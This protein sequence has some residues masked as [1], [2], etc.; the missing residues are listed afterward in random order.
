MTG[1]Q[2]GHGVAS[3]GA[4]AGERALVIGFGISGRA[5]AT[6]LAAEGAEVRVSEARTLE[7]LRAG[8]EAD[9]SDPGEAGPI[10]PGP[11]PEVEIVAGGHRPEHLDG[12][13]L[14]V[15]S[16]GVPQGAEVLAWAMERGLPIWSELEL[17][18]RLC[19]VPVVAVTGTNGKT[20][21]VQL[22]AGMMRAAGMSA[23]ACGNVGYPF[24][25]AAR[26]P[27]VEALAVECSSFQLV[28]QESL[29]PRVSVLLNLAP[30][31]LDWHGS[32][33]A[34]ARAKARIF[35]GQRPGD[36]H[37]GNRDDHQSARVS[38]TAPCTVRWFGWGPPAPG[39]VG[40]DGGRILAASADRIADL[41][42]PSTGSRSF[43][44]D[45][46]A[47]AA[48]GLAFGLSSEA[49][50]VALQTFVPLPHRGTVVAQAGSVRFIDDS[51]ATNPHA[52]LAALEDQHDA[53]L[54]AGG[55]AKGVDLS[56][57]ASAA[58]N[59]TAVVAIGQAAQAVAEVFEGRVPVHRAGSMEDA[60]EMAFAAAPERGT[61][62]LAPACASQDMFRDYRERGERFAAAAR[63]VSSRAVPSEGS[64]A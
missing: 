36:A 57:L 20:T 30:D 47:A 21:T 56:P 31:H 17:G 54:I 63:A 24:S 50:G 38:R 5:A 16:P 37:V 2:R 58:E 23:A 19:R 59:L 6:V 41:G 9:R 60:V 51:K 61:V 27:S 28:F 45:S 55:L 13:T 7:E 34:Y 15:V 22:I 29:R 25:L 48:A 33:D 11:V 52:A 26:D 64:Y 10:Q 49:I 39:E 8:A 43:L 46:A 18:A 62:I 44:T 1:P 53:V 12:A 35:S 14:V 42:A 3:T 4:F 32:F 40:V